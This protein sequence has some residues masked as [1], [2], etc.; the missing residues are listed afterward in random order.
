MVIMQYFFS[1]LWSLF[2]L[3]WDGALLGHIAFH[4]LSK[5]IEV[6][7]R[8]CVLDDCISNVSKSS[9]GHYRHAIASS[10]AQVIGN[11]EGLT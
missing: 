10:S 9:T 5:D 6:R 11:V 2:G 7:T 8:C 4:Y 3:E 1:N